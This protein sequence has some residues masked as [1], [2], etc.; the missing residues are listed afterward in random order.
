M[1]A[2]WVGLLCK[3]EFGVGEGEGAWRASQEQLVG[4]KHVRSP[5]ARHS[6]CTGPPFVRSGIVISHAACGPAP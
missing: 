1:E 5:A 6:Q 2:V 4:G 3:E